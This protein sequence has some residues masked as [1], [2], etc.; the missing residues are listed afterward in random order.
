M[1]LPL[2]IVDINVQYTIKLLENFEEKKEGNCNYPILKNAYFV[3]WSKNWKKNLSNSIIINKKLWIIKKYIKD[4]TN[5]N[6]KVFKS[7][8]YWRILFK[9]NNEYLFIIIRAEN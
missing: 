4:N 2:T 7:I 3:L 5:E 1:I 8:E 6:K 9:E